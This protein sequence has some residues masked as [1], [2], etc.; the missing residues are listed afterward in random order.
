M[1]TGDDL[2]GLDFAKLEAFIEKLVGAEINRDVEKQINHAV[3]YGGTM[4]GRMRGKSIMQSI[5][6][7]EWSIHT[8]ALDESPIVVDKGILLVEESSFKS[9][10]AELRAAN[11]SVVV[12]S[13]TGRTCQIEPDRGMDYWAGVWTDEAVDEPKGTA[14]GKQYKG[15]K[16]PLPHYLGSRRRY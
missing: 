8:D 16:H 15:E 9:V 4:T 6:M 5:P 12:T 13:P 7:P 10:C 11:L 2:K 1:N 3:L 14:T